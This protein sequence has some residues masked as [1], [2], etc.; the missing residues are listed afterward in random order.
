MVVIVVV[1]SPRKNGFGDILAQ[2]IVSGIRSVGKAAEIYRLNDLGPLRQCQNCEVCKRNGGHCVQD[3]KITSLLERIRDAEG[4][5]HVTSIN[6]NHV[7]GLFKVYFDRFYCFLD[8]TAA[9]TLPK[10]K[11]IAT[12]VTASADETA[13]EK[14]SEEYEKIMVQHFFCESVGRIAYCTWMQPKGQFI[15]DSVLSDAEEIGRLF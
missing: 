4:I 14:E 8:D 5:V 15:D 2:R 12:V 13:A 3:D 11:K 6:F 1:S 9:T 7:N 10:G